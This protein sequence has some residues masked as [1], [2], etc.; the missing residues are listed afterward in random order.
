MTR[1]TFIVLINA[2]SIYWWLFLIYSRYKT[3]QREAKRRAKTMEAWDAAYNKALKDGKG[4][5][6][7]MMEAAK[8][9][10]ARQT[11]FKL[12]DNVYDKAVNSG[13]NKSTAGIRATAAARKEAAR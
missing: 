10:N 6:Y 4:E 11:V 9:I 1:T 7:A 5:Y 8:A 2:F 3:A 13:M 12:W